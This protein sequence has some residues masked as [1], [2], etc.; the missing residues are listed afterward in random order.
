M[1]RTNI[2]LAMLALVATSALAHDFEVKNPDGVS[3][4]YTDVSATYGSNAVEVSYQGTWYDAYKDEYKNTVVIP[5]SI[6]AGGKTYKVVGIGEQAFSRCFSLKSITIPESI[7][8][9]KNKA[10]ESCCHLRT[11]NYNAIN[12]RDLT[13]PSFAPFSFGNVAY[14]EYVY[15]ADGDPESF[16]SAYDLRTINIGANVEHIPA[17]MFYG[18]GGGLQQADLTTRPYTIENS[19]EGVNKITFLGN[20]KSIGNQA[21]RSCRLLREISLPESVTE[22]GQAMFADCDTLSEVQLPSGMV[23]IPAYFFSNCK[24]LKNINYPAGLKRINYEAFKN[25]AKLTAVALPEGLTQV[26]PSAFRSC[27]NLKTVMLPSTLTIIDGYAFSDCTSMTEITIPASVTE[28]GNYAFEDCTHLA[29]VTMEGTTRLIGNFV[30][31]GCLK[32]SEGE[33]YAPARMPKIGSRTFEGVKSTMKVIVEGGD[34]SEYRQDE[35]WGRFFMPTAVENVEKADSRHARKV[36][37]DGAVYIERNGCYFDILG[38]E[39]KVKD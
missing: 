34:D 8:Y 13:L 18:M 10:F 9:I 30:F 7:E 16:W 28:I 2:I 39:V 33:F 17:F 12:C 36:M 27:E 32:L 1:K 23:E 21:F 3:I 22:F 37:I 26:G 31:A 20:P 14:G 38:N 5:E 24:E 4:W 6:T 29:T 15:D 25:C 35:N 19:R 11:V